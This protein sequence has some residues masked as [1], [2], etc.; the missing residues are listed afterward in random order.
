M[1]SLELPPL[2]PRDDLFGNPEKA[3]PHISPDGRRL[4]YLAPDDRVLNVWVR[5]LGKDDDRVVTRDRKRGI[6]IYFWSYDKARL[7]YLQD[8]DGD[9]N[10]HVWSVDLESDIIRDLTPFQGAQAHLIAADHRYPTELLVGL[11]I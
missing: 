4:A 8:H 11:N 3:M 5:T 10:W 1:I 2:I 6:R 9:E 7:L